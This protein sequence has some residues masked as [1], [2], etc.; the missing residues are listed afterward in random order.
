VR[1]RRN[2]VHRRDNM[3]AALGETWLGPLSF[4]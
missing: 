2:F 4:F 3:L 1:A